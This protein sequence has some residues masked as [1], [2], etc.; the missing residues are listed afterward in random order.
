MNRRQFMA[1]TAALP[2]LPLTGRAAVESEPDVVIIGAG[3]AGIAAARALSDAGV[4]FAL[5][6]AGGHVG[7]RAWTD[8]STFGVPFDVGAHWVS[9]PSRSARLNPYYTRGKES[10]Y[11]FYRAPDAYRVFTEE[12]EANS[13]E[14]EALWQTYGDMRRRIGEAGDSSRDVAPASVVAES[15]EWRNTA[16]FLLGP[17]DMAKDLDSFS[18][19]DWWHSED[20]DDWYCAQGYGTLVADHLGD[21]PVTL[22]TRVRK[23]DWKG[24][25][26]KVDT[27]QGEIRARAVIVTVSTGVLANDGIT[28]EPALSTDK[29]EAFNR[30]SMGH[31]NHIAL[32]F[33]EDIFGMGEDGYVLHQV[34]GSNEAIGTLTNA[35]GSGLAYCDVGGSFA[36]DLEKA[37]EDAAIDFAM[38]KLRGMIG[39]DVDRHFVKGAATGWGADSRFHGAYASAEPG[40]YAFRRVLREPVGERVFFAGEACHDSLW[41]TVGGADRSGTDTANAAVKHLSGASRGA[42]PR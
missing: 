24:S 13:S 28:F 10:D 33:K 6:E 9:T 4:S 35:S 23:I 22:D 39:S 11:R 14:T 3:A 30:V 5:V 7:G 17:W 8:T 1:L 16:G 2:L 41:A 12:R 36:R 29:V 21:I 31:S 20:L 26:V 34:D 32:Q 25:G 38:G 15:G 19:L 18:C 27:S 40:A 42:S 37:G